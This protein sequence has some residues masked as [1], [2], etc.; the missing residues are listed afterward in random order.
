VL[1]HPNDIGSGLEITVSDDRNV[2]GFDHPGDLVPVG[3]A[4]EHLGPG[5][6]MQG[7]DLRSRVLHPQGNRHRIAGLVVPATPSLDRYR[8]VSRS[9]HRTNDALH[10]VEV[11]EAPR[12]AVPLHHLLHRTAEVDVDELGLIVLGDQAGRLGHC[13]WVRPVNL[14]SDRP[15][16]GLELRALECGPDPAADRLRRQEF[17]Q[18][19]VGTHS[20][21]DLA[22]RSLRHSGHGS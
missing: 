8:Q 9:D 6:G 7:E 10:Q 12:S 18:H 13:V 16:D 3:A 17:G 14:D 22:E 5:P 2:E 1:P 4:R 11:P 15:L 19:D 20:P 21:A